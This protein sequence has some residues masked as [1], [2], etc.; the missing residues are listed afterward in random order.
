M[1]T[2]TSDF[3]TPYP[4][5]M[6]GVI[7]QRTDTRLVDVA[8]DLPRQDVRSAAF[9]L[10]EVLPYFPLATHLVVVD[11]G[12]GTDRNALVVRAGDHVLVGP[13]NGVL[14]PAARRLADDVD[15]E[16]YV[17][18]ETRL[19][20]PDAARS[21][22][23][24]TDAGPASNTFHGRDV[25]APAA[26]K[27]HE[28]GPDALETLSVLEPATEYVSLDLPEPTLSANR[29]V[30]EILVVDDFGNAITNVPGSFLEDRERITLD[31][32]TVPVGETFASVPVGDRLATVGSHGYVELDV[33]QG[34]GDEAFGLE[35]GDEVVLETAD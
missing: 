1:I 8:H 21:I 28:V 20:A 34:R 5:A 4:A 10:R 11:P 18:D 35:V 32:E 16:E 2:L 30:G 25:F 17:V 7:L 27:A 23:S 24:A 3:G 15:L 13:D 31:G 26:A 29:A 19:E 12:V 6:K 14:L 22:P 33:N 9:W